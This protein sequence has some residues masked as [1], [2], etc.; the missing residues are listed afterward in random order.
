MNV[1][2]IV[3]STGQYG[4]WGAGETLAAAEANRIKAKGKRRDS[5]RVMKFESALPF[6]PSGRDATDNEAD[7]FVGKDGTINWIR[8]ERVQDDI[9]S[10]KQLTS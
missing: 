4:T 3:M 1:R 8:C 6:A 10:A 5:V 2:F 9:A 7:A